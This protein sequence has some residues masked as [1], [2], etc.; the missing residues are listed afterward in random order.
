M[1]SLLPLYNT[2]INVVSLWIFTSESVLECPVLERLS[3]APR[4]R[5]RPRDRATPAP[6]S[7]PRGNR[8]KNGPQRQ[9]RR[10]GSGE[11]SH[12]RSPIWRE[13][14]EHGKNMEIP[15]RCSD[16]IPSASTNLRTAAVRPCCAAAV[17][18]WRLGGWVG[19]SGAVHATSAVLLLL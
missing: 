12:P 7:S 13:I 1:Y 3:R 8:R 11:R 17:N 19:G 5:P 16:I 14:V 6:H 2:L 15:T 10:A 9:T 4:D 18:R